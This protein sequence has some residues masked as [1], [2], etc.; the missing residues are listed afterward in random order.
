V[1]R[2]AGIPLPKNA[3]KIM[4]KKC[5]FCTLENALIINGLKAMKAINNLKA[6]T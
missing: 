6:A 4:G 2:N 1:N 5:F 3:V